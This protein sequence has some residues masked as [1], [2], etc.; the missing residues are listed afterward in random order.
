VE[1]AADLT[2][3]LKKEALRAGFDACGISRADV[4][5]PESERLQNWL[6]EGLHGTM[7]WM[8]N[9]Y[10]KR[11]DPRELVPGA[12]SV[13]SVLQN[14]YQPVPLPDSPEMGKI[15]RYA[16]GEDYHEV[17]KI[18][19]RGLF[20]WLRHET[21]HLNGRIFVDSAPVMDKA[22]AAR[23]G[24]GWQGKHTNLINPE[25]GS[26]FFIGEMIVDTD[27]VPDSPVSDMC[28]TCTRCIEACPTDAIVQPYVVDATRCISY[29]TIEHRADDIDDDLRALSGNWIF[30]CD[31]CQDV[32]PWNKFQKPSG[33]SA[34]EPGDGLLEIHLETWTSQS[35][36]QFRDTFRDTFRKSPVKRTKWEGFSRNIRNALLNSQRSPDRVTDSDDEQDRP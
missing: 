22:W 10:S 9:H 21:T 26:W 23:A 34:Y 31:I 17:M 19:L 16:L 20:E 13:V 33:E 7:R 14:Y 18:K 15:S 32:C 3:R 11:V 25:L 29:L 24:L 6:N 36:E 27:L 35:A 30:G 8:E 28:G 12:R 5:D 4:L 2:R 1:T